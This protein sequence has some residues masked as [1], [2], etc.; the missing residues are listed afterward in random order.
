[1]DGTV[2]LAVRGAVAEIALAAGP[3]NLVTRPLLR[4]LNA[5]IRDLAGRAGI[6]CV[7]LHG[8]EG[9]AFC[10]GSDIREFADLR[11]DAS[12]HKILFEDMVLRNLARLPMPTIAAIDGP[13]LG[14]GLE[15]ALA[16]DLRVLRRGVAVGLTESR[17]GGLAGNGSVRLTR[18]V[19]PARAKEMLFTGETISDEQALAW[20]VVNRIA[21]GSALDAARAMAATIAARGPVSNRLAKALVDAAQDQ[22]LDAALCAS[23]VAQQA[24]FDS[25]DLH[26]GVAAFFAKREPEFDGR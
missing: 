15:L 22:A 8:G 16:C 6:R 5:A 3:L 25:S 24:I 9:R 26:T 12:E 21:D 13:A 7:I 2:S 4:D 1:M 20:G 23:T 19:G 18:L 14:G 10:A 11:A 17:L